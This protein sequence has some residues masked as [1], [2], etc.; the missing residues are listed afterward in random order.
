MPLADFTR[1]Q[2]DR[3]KKRVSR[4][5]FKRI[6]P[7]LVNRPI[8]ILLGGQ[9]ASG[10]TNLIETIKRNTPDRQFVVINGDEF[11]TYHPNYTA[12]YSQYGTDAPHHTQPFSNAMVEW[13]A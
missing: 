8:G 11:R 5:L 10:K 9:P 12:I 3:Q 13:A 4:K 2:F 1:R 7:Q 6:K